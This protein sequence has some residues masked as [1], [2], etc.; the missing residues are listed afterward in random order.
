[1]ME[2]QADAMNGYFRL[3]QKN[4]KRGLS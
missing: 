4:N 3:E 1:M 2:T